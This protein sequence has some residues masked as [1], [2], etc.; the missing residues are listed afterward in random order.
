MAVALEQDA[1]AGVDVDDPSLTPSPQPPGDT[2][3]EGRS[4]LAPLTPRRIGAIAVAW[5]VVTV[6]GLGLV[7]YGMGPMLEERDQRNLLGDYRTAIYQA[8]QE[9]FG[10]GGVDEVTEAPAV[11]DPVAIV[12]I[13]SIRF[14]QVAVEGVGPQQT[15]RGPGHVPGTAGP[16]QPGNSVIVGRKTGFGGQFSQLDELG[17][18]DE[19]VV[20]TTQGKSLYKVTSVEE[21]SVSGGSEKVY[22]PSD[23]DRLT[24]VTS[25]SV[26][27][28][29]TNPATVVTAKL[30]TIAF[31]PTPQGG[32]TGDL[33]GRGR[34]GSALAPVFLAVI[35]YACAAAGAVLLYRR[36]RPRS[37]YLMSAPL[38]VVATVLLAEA[39]ARLLP[40]WF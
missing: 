20:I 3:R 18:G 34:D 21:R 33:D 39:S 28:W 6:V 35:A 5:V 4:R 22:G 25:N 23:D 10:I 30:K 1:A 27:P 17:R 37:A 36:T 13:N 19:I 2:S 26:W 38:L 16:G 24:L 8:S 11:G 7:V 15:R 9:A 32:R 12:E 14:R 29:S 40:A 31:H